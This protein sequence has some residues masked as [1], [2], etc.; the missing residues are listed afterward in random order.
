MQIFEEQ[1]FGR[2]HAKKSVLQLDEEIEKVWISVHFN[3]SFQERGVSIRNLKYSLFYEISGM[4]GSCV[5]AHIFR[6]KL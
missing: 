1:H 3:N 4:D 5:G 2:H 6:W